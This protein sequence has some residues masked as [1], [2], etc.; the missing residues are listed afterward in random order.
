MHDI[1][2]IHLSSIFLFVERILFSDDRLVT[3]PGEGGNTK[4]LS[5]LLASGTDY[6]INIYNRFM[7]STHV[8]EFVF[9]VMFHSFA[10]R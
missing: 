4:I 1:T 10:F 7:L 8:E 3:A 9:I 2:I 5:V 6:I